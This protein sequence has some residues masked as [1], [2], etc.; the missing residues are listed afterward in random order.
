MGIDITV[1]IGI[2]A[3]LIHLAGYT[4]YNIQA[5]RGHSTPNLTSWGLWAFLAALS[6]LTYSAFS[7]DLVTTS[8]FYAGT[9]AQIFTLLFALSTGKFT[10]PKREE[11]IVILLALIA[12][13]IWWSD[14]N[15]GGA[16][17]VLLAATLLGGV[18]TILGVWRNPKLE[19][20]VPWLLWSLAFLLTIV[21]VV[22]RGNGFALNLAM[23]VAGLVLH[24]T[25]AILAFRRIQSH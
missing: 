6:A 25:V 14:R 17:L 15:A 23:P 11:Y 5:H 24:G 21:N 2:V 13:Y 12:I 22:L 8:I 4:L 20:P 1:V 10:A 18:P 9:A 19:K 7:H 16:N 3:V